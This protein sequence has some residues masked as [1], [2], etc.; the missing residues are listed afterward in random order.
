[1]INYEISVR[2]NLLENKLSLE[3]TAFRAKGDNLIQ[4]VAGSNGTKYQNT[5]EFTNTGVEFIGTCKPID[6]LTLNANYSYISMKNH[7]IASPE[8]QLFISG[9]YKWNSL[10]LNISVQHIHNLY[11]RIT[12]L[13]EKTSY[14][15]L[16]SRISYVIN[17]YVDVF[18]KGENLTNKKYYINYAYPMP[19]IIA[20]AG[21]NMHF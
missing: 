18:V 15:L 21:L 9:T 8:Q 3:L 19:G 16:N 20:F 7:I 12:P 11:T 13:E 1:M 10:S 6:K 4:T 5:G 2:Q 17:K 14:T